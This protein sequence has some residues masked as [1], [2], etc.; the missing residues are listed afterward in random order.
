MSYIYL[1]RNMQINQNMY[2]FIYSHELQLHKLY[3][4]TFYVKYGCLYYFL[5]LKNSKYS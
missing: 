3:F 2:F 5:T 4:S 1:Y